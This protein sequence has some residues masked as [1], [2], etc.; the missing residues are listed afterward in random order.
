MEKTEDGIPRFSNLFFLVGL[1]DL[2]ELLKRVR[3]EH[4]SVLRAIN[5]VSVMLEE[6]SMMEDEESD[7]EDKDE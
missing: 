5:T 3:D 1:L 2:K 7:E 6:V 4:G